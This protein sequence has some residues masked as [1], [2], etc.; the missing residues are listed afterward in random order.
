MPDIR[1]RLEIDDAII[2]PS[3][4]G[5]S[6]SNASEVSELAMQVS[7]SLQYTSE[8]LSV[9][10]KLSLTCKSASDLGFPLVSNCDVLLPIN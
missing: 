6:P 1:I 4:L 2:L 5:P 10:S 3:R 9:T 8:L 7:T